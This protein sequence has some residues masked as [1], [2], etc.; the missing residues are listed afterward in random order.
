MQNAPKATKF[1][2]IMQNRGYYTIQDHS[3]SVPVESSYVTSY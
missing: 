2:E 1:G 3:T